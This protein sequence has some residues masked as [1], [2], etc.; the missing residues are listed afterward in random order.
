MLASDIV[1]A[2]AITLTGI[3][4]SPL[5]SIGATVFVITT[6]DLQTFSCGAHGVPSRSAPMDFYR[7]EIY[8]F[9]SIMVYQQILVAKYHITSECIIVT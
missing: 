6:N 8:D 4:V 2:K 1:L 3:F 5:T 9:Y 7:S